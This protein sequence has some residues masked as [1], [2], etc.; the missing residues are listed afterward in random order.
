MT[1]VEFS[2]FI[3]VKYRYLVTSN[4]TPLLHLQGFCTVICNMSNS[5]VRGFIATAAVVEKRGVWSLSKLCT[6]AV[7]LALDSKP[8]ADT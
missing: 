2:V 4:E 1:A 8:T 5:I 6:K 7:H 3:V